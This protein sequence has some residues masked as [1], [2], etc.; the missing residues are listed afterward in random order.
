MMN[1]NKIL[2]VGSN[3]PP[4]R[5]PLGPDGMTATSR[6]LNHWMESAGITA[7]AFTNVIPYHVD[8]EHNS[9][10]DWDRVREKTSG[11]DRIVA[12]GGFS[13]SVLTRLRIKHLALPHPSPR[14]R[15]FNDKSFESTVI[16]QL[17]TYIK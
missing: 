3:P 11:F 12:L 8:V 16:D 2:F 1:P 7:H 13:S 17:K 14:N 9:H 10:V 6:R 4:L 5:R 15:K